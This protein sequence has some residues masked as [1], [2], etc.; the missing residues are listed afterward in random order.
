LHAIDGDLTIS[1]LA[2]SA[3]SFTLSDGTLQVA[4]NV[5]VGL[6]ASA[7]PSSSNAFIQS[8]GVNQIGGT[9]IVGASGGGQY[10]LSGG[11]LQAGNELV[12]ALGTGR[13]VFNQS[14][15]V[16]TVSGTLTIGGGPGTSGV[17]NLSSGII[18][19]GT[20]QT[21]GLV[22]NDR[23]NITGVSQI[24][25]NVLNNASGT[26]TVTGATLNVTGTVTNF[27]TITM[28]PSRVTVGGLTLGASGVI[29]AGPGDVLAVLGDFINFSVENTLWN[30]AAAEL[31]FAGGGT[32][33][34]A[35]AGQNQ[36]GFADNFAWGMLA[37]GPGD[38]L[39][40]ESGSGDALYVGIL[41]GLDIAGDLITNIFGAD[42]LFIYY[43]VA[44]NP[45]LHGN[46]LL[47][48]GG[49]LIAFDSSGGGA[50][51]PE[52]PSLAVLLAGLA[53]VAASG[54]LGRHRSR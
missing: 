24:A 49:E 39:R 36:A 46:Y 27:G 19:A 47:A 32:H 5:R 25:A 34:F 40:L 44:D 7:V 42:G 48:G 52:P 54:W 51:V 1:A 38:L 12:G 13:G 43:D 8:G 50:A 9:L 4:G 17:Y 16:N 20:P 30:T 37:L 28:D 33:L 31:D 26:I 21:Q 53:A 22:N 11:S 35:L 14:G 15:G 41:E 3:G 10:T 18:N 2:G 6:D 45:L 23:L 29:V